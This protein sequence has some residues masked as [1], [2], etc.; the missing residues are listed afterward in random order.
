MLSVPRLCIARASE[1]SEGSQ[2]RHT[3]KYDYESCGTRKQESL[4]RANSNLMCWKFVDDSQSRETLNMVMSPA[5]LGTKNDCAGE[6]QQQFTLPYP[7]RH[8]SVIQR[9]LGTPSRRGGSISKHVEVLE[10]KIRSW[11][12]TGL[13]TKNYCAGDGQ[14][15]FNRLTNR[16]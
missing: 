7:A 3:V 8:E 2:S 6:G 14:Q 12:P 9:Q 5:G 15:Q 13:E 1:W 11:V 10:R 4:A 16:S